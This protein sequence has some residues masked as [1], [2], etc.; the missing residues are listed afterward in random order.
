MNSHLDTATNSY[1]LHVTTSLS[2]HAIDYHEFPSPDV[3]DGT[4]YGPVPVLFRYHLHRA[5]T[6]CTD[7]SYPY[8]KVD[9]G[10]ISAT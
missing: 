5:Q 8:I 6:G 7:Y 2:H 9:T 4:I 1:K 3:E 10:I